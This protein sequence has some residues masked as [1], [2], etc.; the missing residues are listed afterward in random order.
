M[1]AALTTH[2]H[3]KLRRCLAS[4]PHL[5]ESFGVTRTIPRPWPDNSSIIRF[6]TKDIPM[7]DRA[8][9]LAGASERYPRDW[10]HCF[11]AERS[12]FTFLIVCPE[13]HDN[14]ELACAGGAVALTTG[15]YS[16][17]ER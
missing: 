15:P 2:C 7:A 14:I 11:F 16:A 10:P 9:L 17:V 1:D 8:R 3:V 12:Q 13:G 5:S 6:P 4:T